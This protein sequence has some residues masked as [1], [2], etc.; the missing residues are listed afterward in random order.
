MSGLTEKDKIEF[1]LRKY[2]S[3]YER[4]NAYMDIAFKA[5]VFFYVVTGSIVGFYLSNSSKPY[6]KIAL[7]IP[8]LLGTVFG[9]IFLYGSYLWRKARRTIKNLEEE[10]IDKE[11]IIPPHDLHLLS[12][13]LLIF[14]IIFIAVAGSMI[15]VWNLM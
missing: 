11:L 9:A 12:W 5:N 6:V 2:A 7:I 4:Y 8:M 13:L 14:G 3:H 15:I 1:Q 10:L